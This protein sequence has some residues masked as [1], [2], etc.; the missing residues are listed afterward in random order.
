MMG[1]PIQVAVRVRLVA[2]LECVCVYCVIWIDIQVSDTYI[3][4]DK[5]T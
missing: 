4:N 5:Y 3:M 2:R 1:V